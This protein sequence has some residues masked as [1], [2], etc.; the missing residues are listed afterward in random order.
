MTASQKNKYY[1][2]L[3]MIKKIRKRYQLKREKENRKKD[4]KEFF[5]KTKEEIKK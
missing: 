4:H 1:F 3:K 2:N 5:Q